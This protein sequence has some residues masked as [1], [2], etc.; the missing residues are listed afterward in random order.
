MAKLKILVYTDNTIAP[1][2]KELLKYPERIEIIEERVPAGVA[3]EAYGT[4]RRLP[5]RSWIDALTAKAFKT[6]GRN[7]DGVMFVLSNWE[8][9]KKKLLGTQPSFL[10][11]TYDLMFVKAG[12]FEGTTATHEIKHTLDNL[13]R[14]HLGFD[15]AALLKVKDW[16][17]DV[18]HRKGHKH[19]FEYKLDVAWKYVDEA[20]KKRREFDK[21]SVMAKTLASLQIMLNT[22]LMKKKPDFSVPDNDTISDPAEQAK[23]LGEKLHEKALSFLGTDASPDDT[24]PDELGCADT[25]SNILRTMIPDFPIIVSTLKLNEYLSKSP[26]FLKVGVPEVGAVL[27]SPTGSGN[28]S[29]VGHTGIC[30]VSDK[31]MSNTSATG[32]FE[33]NYTIKTWTDRYM[34]KGGFPMHYY[35]LVK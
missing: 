20:I 14:V 2:Y 22:L 23:T 16:D 3:W 15:L 32:K 10:S 9:G 18:V 5:V 27:I 35:R 1:I 26:H 29:L 34:R 4:E 17:D 6:Y 30:S 19:D 12:G 8:N 33:A 31:I 28:G 13:V 24:A 11:N 21:L 25:V 7:I